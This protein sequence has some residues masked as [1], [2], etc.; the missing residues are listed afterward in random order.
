MATEPITREIAGTCVNEFGSAI[1]MPQ[2]L[3][4]GGVD[5][6]DGTAATASQILQEKVLHFQ[7]FVC[8]SRACLG[9]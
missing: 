8:L 9:K 4:D 7:C 1:G 5:Y 3:E 6:E 2:Q